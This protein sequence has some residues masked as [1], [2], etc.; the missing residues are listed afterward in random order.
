MQIYLQPTSIRK[1]LTLTVLIFEYHLNT[2]THEVCSRLRQE[3]GRPV[4]QAE[5]SVHFGDVLE[6]S[7]PCRG[8]VAYA[9]ESVREAVNGSRVSI[10]TRD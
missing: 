7:P 5:F 9:C 10:R 4:Y 3:R 8:G 1:H 6:V 2:K